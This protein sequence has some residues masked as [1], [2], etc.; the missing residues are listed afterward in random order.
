MVKKENEDLKQ[1]VENLTKQTDAMR[2]S[3]KLV[4][5]KEKCHFYTGLAPEVFDVTYTNLC[6]YAPPARKD[7]LSLRD[8]FFL[9]LVKLRRNIPFEMISDLTGPSESTVRNYFWRWIDIMNARLTFLIHW[10][11]RDAIDQNTPT[12]FRAKFPRLTSI[13]DC[14]EIFIQTP[15]NYL[16]RSQTYSNYKHHCTVMY[17][18]AS[19][20]L[21]AVCF[22]SK[23][24]GGRVSDVELVR[25]SGF[26]SQKYHYPR[27][28]ILADRGFT[29]QDEFAAQ[30]SVELIIPPFTRGKDQLPAEDVERGRKISSIRIHV[31]RVIGLLKN[32]F[33]IL[34]G[35]LPSSLIKMPTEEAAEL[36][37]TGVDRIIHVCAA[38]L[39]LGGGIVEKHTDDKP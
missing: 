20:P 5:N 2:L 34:D 23:G 38:L 37:C 26:M 9:T 30:L 7:S 15:C 21:G 29:Q 17:L 6:K 24:W 27:D 28:Q 35:P 32:R 4:D 25:Q 1:L 39:N 22:I 33:T 16:A 31:E 13:I 19:S 12:E 14:F 18:I 8:Q 11:D 10:P 3:A 36:D